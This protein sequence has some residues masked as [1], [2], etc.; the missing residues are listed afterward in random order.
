[1]NANENRLKQCFGELPRSLNKHPEPAPPVVASGT[2]VPLVM[3]DGL[4]S[5]H[6][7]KWNSSDVYGGNSP[8]GRDPRADVT[9]ELLKKK[10]KHSTKQLF[11]YV[12]PTVYDPSEKM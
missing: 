11:K 5:Q 12:V 3:D 9:V 7:A 1:M 6:G 10:K 2:I 4:Q 8:N